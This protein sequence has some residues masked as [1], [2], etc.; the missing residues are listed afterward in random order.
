M[1]QPPHHQGSDDERVDEAAAES[2]PASDAPSWTAAHLGPPPPFPRVAE[3][4]HE[5]RAALRTDMDR[6]RRAA[7][8]A[9]AGGERQ[10]DLKQVEDLIARS[11]LEAG[12]SVV[13]EPIDAAFNL[14]NVEAEQR[15]PSDGPCVIL[16]ARYDG[17]D[18]TGI[19]MLLAVLRAASSARTR[20]TLR[21]AAFATAAGS[22]RYVARLAAEGTPVRA[23][24]SLVR[25][26]L[27]RANRGNAVYFVG[28]LR[29]RSVARAARSA[30]RGSSRVRARSLSLPAWLPGVSA[31]EHTPFWQA[32]IPAAMVADAPPWLVARRALATPDVD[33]MAAAVP[34]L[35]AAVVRLAGGHV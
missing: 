6:L 19:A 18:P 1:A 23:M 5:L 14:C 31:A 2:F 22:R 3:H 26:D 30:F 9:G 24:L 13:R 16:G 33:W 21:F 28:N 17:V 29:S 35:V 34:G 25:L 27:S 15:G 7:G 8:A 32:G 12:R 4:G 20:L 11:M 10:G